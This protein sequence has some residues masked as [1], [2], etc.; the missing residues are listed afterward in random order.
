MNKI[1]SVEIHNNSMRAAEIHNPSGKKPKI[2]KV[3]T[4][5]LP[6]NVAGESLVQDTTVFSTMVHEMWKNEKFSTKD[7]ALVVSGRRFIVR[8]HSTNHVSM[9][10]FKKVIDFE[11][12]SV[13]P[14][15]MHDPII[16]FYPMFHSE[17]KTGI[18]TYGLIIATPA[19]PIESIIGAFIQAGLNVKSIEFAPTSI[20]RFLNNYSDQKDYAVVNIRE[21]SSDIFLVKDNIIRIIRVV[22]VGFALIPKK[23]GKRVKE[24]NESINGEFLAIQSPIE[25]LSREILLTVQS[26]EEEL[27][28]KFQHIFVTGNR[29]H[30]ESFIQELNETLGKDF[31]LQ[32]FHVPEELKKSDIDEEVLENNFVAICAGLRNKK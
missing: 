7:I 27:E 24:A 30:D 18:R 17:E 15:Q 1:V 13:I 10:D 23:R 21:F 31:T 32:S 3:S 19:E 6:L 20:A 2:V 14:T 26:Q 11:A 22:P 25:Q 9:N 4:L 29:S 5:D 16:D 8:Q 12:A 28:T